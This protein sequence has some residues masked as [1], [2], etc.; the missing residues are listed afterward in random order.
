MTAANC[1]SET[2]VVGTAVPFHSICA[3]YTNC[4]PATVTV[5]V[6]SENPDG[7][8]VPR[9]GIGF[10]MASVTDPGGKVGS[11][12]ATLVIFT[13]LGTGTIAGAV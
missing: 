11:L 10:Q 5:V 13:E 4:D 3:P 2:S 8:T 9:T 6:P 1:E 12:P 7:V